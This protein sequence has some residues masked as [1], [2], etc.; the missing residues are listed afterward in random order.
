MNFIS[1]NVRGLESPDRKYIAK[2]F[3][4]TIKNKDF[5]MLQ[6][7]KAVDFMLDCSLDI[8]WK[9]SIKICTA[10]SKGRGGT[11]LLINPKWTKYIMDKGR[12]PCNSSVWASFC[13]NNVSFGICSVYAP[14]DP[15]ER[16]DLWLWLTSLP[17]IPWI[18][19]GD[20]NMIESQIDKSGGRPFSWKLAEID[21]WNNMI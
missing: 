3:L 21:H 11:A 17:D 9:D 5:I 4:D 13:F 19:G 15:M 12:S 1:W 16:A 14:N 6:E 2:H 7:L 8:I 10:H 18:L 20:F